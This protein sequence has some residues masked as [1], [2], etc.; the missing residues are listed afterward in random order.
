MRVGVGLIEGWGL[1]EEV[2]VWFQVPL[3]LDFALWNVTYLTRCEN[4]VVWALNHYKK[5]VYGH[6][7]KP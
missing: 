6:G 1:Q 3:S 5:K 4:G 7:K 2:G